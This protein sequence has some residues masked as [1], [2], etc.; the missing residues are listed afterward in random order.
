MM[1]TRIGGRAHK[2]RQ[3]RQRFVKTIQI[4]QGFGTMGA[5]PRQTGIA[6]SAALSRPPALQCPCAGGARTCSIEGTIAL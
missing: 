3:N 2:F 6:A 5:N 4:L 1:Q